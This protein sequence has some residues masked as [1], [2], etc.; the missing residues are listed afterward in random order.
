MTMKKEQTKARNSPV[1]PRRSQ[2]AFRHRLPL[3]LR[4]LN[5]CTYQFDDPPPVHPRTVVDILPNGLRFIHC[6][7]N[8]SPNHLE[9]L[10]VI[11]TGSMVENEGEHEVIIEE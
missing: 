1:R 2:I 10:L 11:N 3:C 6:E 7:N 9:L 4:L 8:W 5:A